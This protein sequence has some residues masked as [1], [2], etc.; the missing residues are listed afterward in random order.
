MVCIIKLCGDK[1]FSVSQRCDFNLQTGMI[2][3]RGEPLRGCVFGF[4]PHY[5]HSFWTRI[6][7]GH[8]PIFLVHQHGRIR[9]VLQFISRVVSH[10]FL[11]NAVDLLA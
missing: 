7:H 9:S 1:Y 6:L 5:F 2:C 4:W 3:P 10:G 11:D 8:V